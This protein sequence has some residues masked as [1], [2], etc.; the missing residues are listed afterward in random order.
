MKAAVVQ[1]EDALIQKL[2]ANLGI[3][4]GYDSLV[5]DLFHDLS[6]PL[7]TVSCVLENQLLVS[8]S[9][10]QYRD[11]LKIALKQVRSIVWH[12][13]ALRELWDAGS[14][15]QN[16]ESLSVAACM[17][18]LAG[19]LLPV[20]ESKKVKLLLATSADCMVHFQ[21]GRLGQALTHLLEFAIQ[22]CAAGAEVEIVADAEGETARIALEI[23]ALELPPAKNPA[24]GC[25]ADRKQ[26]E[27]KARLDLAVAWRV[28]AVVGGDLRVER[29][30]D[31]L[32]L[33]VV[34]PL[35]YR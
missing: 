32:R 1:A 3:D 24:E 17:R 34:L 29:N 16:Q 31:R 7:S 12:F 30:E 20:A 22:F 11:D 26:C 8:R 2:I 19:D 18:D 35:A 21:A 33:G 5:R 25:A 15:Q 6:Q 13:H 4:G 27:L 23:S 10:K 28:F 9:P 14:A